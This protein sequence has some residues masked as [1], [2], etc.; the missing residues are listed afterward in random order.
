MVEP[1]S[2][3]PVMIVQIN[4]FL[5]IY[6]SFG[7]PVLLRISE[8]VS[9]QAHTL[10]FQVRFLGPPPKFPFL[11]RENEGLEILELIT[12]VSNFSK[13]F[14]SVACLQSKKRSPQCK[15]VVLLP[16]DD[17]VCSLLDQSFAQSGKAV[18]FYQSKYGNSYNRSPRRLN[19]EQVSDVVTDSIGGSLSL[20]FLNQLR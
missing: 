16:V 19:L 8:I 2:P 17:A 9:R 14:M 10:Q 4:L 7:P 6:G 18:L 3:K 20:L 15:G 12:K 5:P 11:L 1:R 13:R